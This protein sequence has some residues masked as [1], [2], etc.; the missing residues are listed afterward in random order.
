MKKKTLNLLFEL[1]LP[2][3]LIFSVESSQ[4][5]FAVRFGLITSATL[6][7]TLQARLSI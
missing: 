7:G 2:F 3:G 5:V 6:I 4:V 1:F